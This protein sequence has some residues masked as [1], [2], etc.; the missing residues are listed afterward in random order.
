M[1][2]ILSFTC[3]VLSE[4]STTVDPQTTWV[5]TVNF[6]ADFGRITIL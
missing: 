2:I 5:C 4:K 6:D 1:I 3:H